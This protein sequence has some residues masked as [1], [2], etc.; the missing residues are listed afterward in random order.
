MLAQFA[1]FALP[2]CVVATVS[3]AWVVSFCGGCGRERGYLG[4]CGIRLCGCSASGLLSV[5]GELCS[6]GSLFVSGATFCCFLVGVCPVFT[7]R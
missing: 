4:M 1:A 7:A 2:N 5:L 3:E 6:F